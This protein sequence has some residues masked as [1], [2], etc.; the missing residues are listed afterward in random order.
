MV[1]KEGNIK[2]KVFIIGIPVVV[3]LLFCFCAWLF[4]GT[5]SQYYY[6]QIDN[7]KMSLNSSDGGVID[8]NGGLDYSYRLPA[9]NDSGEEKSITFNTSKELRDGAFIRLEVVPIRGV[10]TWAEIQYE[11]M[12]SIVQDNYAVPISN[13]GK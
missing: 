1:R 12:P 2:K 3:I 11:D 6:A 13:S 7:S 9:F 10:I 8:F 4:I 5:D